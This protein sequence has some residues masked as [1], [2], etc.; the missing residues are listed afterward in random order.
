MSNPIDKKH[1][2]RALEL[3]V[4]LHRHG[5][6]VAQLTGIAAD[7]SPRRYARLTKD[8]GST[9]ILM[10]ADDKQHNEEFVALATLLHG[11]GLHTPKIYG[12]HPAAGLV[13]MED[14]GGETFGSHID[15]SSNDK[16][17]I[18]KNMSAADFYQRG[19]DVLIT[20]HTKFLLSDIAPPFPPLP[21]F[22]AQLFA[23]QAMLYLDAF[24]PMMGVDVVTESVRDD[25]HD[26]WVKALHPA[27][28]L[29]QTLM[30]RDFTLENLILAKDNTTGVLDF[31]D[32]GIG[33]IAYDI[34]S[35]CDVVRRDGGWAHIPKLLDSYV[36]AV[37][38]ACTRDELDQACVVLSAQ[39][40]LRVLGIVAK[41]IVTGRHD[42]IVML[43]RIKAHLGTLMP[44]DALTPVRNWLQ[45]HQ[46]EELT[47]S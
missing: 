39:R 34:V 45:Q 44:H 27:A 33:P 9:A 42:K 18:D 16:G 23:D 40:H 4:F 29:P 6:D 5:W 47:L 24:L 10:D 13:V 15:K 20:L 25:F 19:L 28:K 1:A 37:K 21:Q 17:L 32:G 36:A 22:N 35:L 31:Q 3:T 43:P 30:L 46:L 14:L 12:A 11:Y 7:F 2:N 38:P 8:D 41:Q 26:A